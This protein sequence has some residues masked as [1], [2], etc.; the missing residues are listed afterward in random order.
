M[1]AQSGPLLSTHSDEVTVTETIDE[2]TKPRSKKKKQ[3]RP[4]P[5]C[6]KPQSQKAFSAYAQ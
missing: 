3:A 6:N 4:C 1:S 2:E 5:F